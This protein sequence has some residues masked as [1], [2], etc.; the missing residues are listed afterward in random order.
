MPNV[1]VRTP[2]NMNLEQC[3]KALVGI[4][5]G[6]GHPACFSGF[7]IRLTMISEFIVDPASFEVKKAL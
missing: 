3:Q 2:A 7:D 1:I 6:V 5:R 4:L